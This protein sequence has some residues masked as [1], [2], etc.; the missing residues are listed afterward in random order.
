MSALFDDSSGIVF[1]SAAGLIVCFGLVSAIPVVS[2]L[3]NMARKCRL[4]CEFDFHKGGGYISALK[5]RNG[6]VILG[7][8]PGHPAPL[9]TYQRD[10]CRF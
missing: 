5:Q 10:R 4:Y 3:Q 9:V 1:A 2:A 7:T 8:I 6:L